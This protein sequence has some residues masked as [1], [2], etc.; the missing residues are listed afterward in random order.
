MIETYLRPTYQHYI[1]NPFLKWAK[2]FSPNII[3]LASCLTGIA[4][5]PLLIL[6][7]GEWAILL[8]LLSGFFD[9]L[10]GTVARATE[11]TSEI[12][13]MF[14]IVSDR[15]VEFAVIFGLFAIDPLHR[16]WLAL[17]MLGSCYLCVTTFL[18]VGIF[19][20]NDSQ[21]GFHYSP[22]LMERAEAFLFFIAMILLPDYFFSLAILFTVLVLLTSYLRVREF[23]AF[24]I[25]RS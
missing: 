18:V 19:T 21:N 23:V 20:Q 1:V 11:K 10:D 17:L 24:R 6:D 15:I 12:G 7:C 9:T 3:T 5:A 14:D 13:S 4:V 16:G 2:L 25:N 8:L 22:G